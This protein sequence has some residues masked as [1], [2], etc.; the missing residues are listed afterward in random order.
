MTKKLFKKQYS[1]FI[2]GEG[3][4]DKDFL[5]TLIDLQNFKYHTSKWTFN[6][7]NSSGG[8]AEAVLEKCHKESSSY[9]F[10]LILCF[11]DLDKL[12]EDFPKNWNKKKIE[13]EV[14]YANIKIVWQIENAEDEYKK[15]LGEIKGKHKTNQQAKK[16]IKKFINSEF[17]Q[18]ILKPIKEREQNLGLNEKE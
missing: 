5:T 2:F 17:W 3:K 8:G 7:S 15:V 4:R 10:D 9:A 14:K 16:Q 6:Y 18:R 1:C 13:L 11:I 12:K